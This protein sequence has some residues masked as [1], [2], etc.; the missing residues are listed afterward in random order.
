M[1]DVEQKIPDDDSP[2]QPI[3]KQPISEA[4]H[5]DELY[6]H[7]KILYYILYPL[8]WLLDINC[9]RKRTWIQIPLLTYFTEVTQLMMAITFVQVH[10]QGLE[11]RATFHKIKVE[12]VALSLFLFT[13]IIAVLCLTLLYC[14][15]RFTTPLHYI[16]FVQLSTHLV[17]YGLLYLCVLIQYEYFSDTV[18]NSWNWFFI[19]LAGACATIAIIILIKIF[20]FKQTSTN[21]LIKQYRKYYQ[22]YKTDDNPNM[23]INNNDSEMIALI[24]TESNDSYHNYELMDAEQSLSIINN[25]WYTVFMLLQNMWSISIGFILIEC[26]VYLFINDYINLLV[27]WQEFRNMNSILDNIWSIILFG[28]VLAIATAFME[29]FMELKCKIPCYQFINNSNN[30]N[31]GYRNNCYH[32]FLVF[33]LHW[34][35]DISILWFDILA[36]CIGWSLLTPNQANEVWDQ[37]EWAILGTIGF[38]V[39]GILTEK[40]RLKKKRNIFKKME[41]IKQDENDKEKKLMNNVRNLIFYEQM[42]KTYNAAFA[43]A[44]SFAWETFIQLALEHTATG[45]VGLEN[46]RLT[47]VLTLVYAIF[48]GF[49]FTEL[50]LLLNDL[51][52]QRLHEIR[53]KNERLNEQ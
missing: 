42:H 37:F 21:H 52:K 49:A 9:I 26:V 44:V 31:I 28:F 46:H 6:C 53:L 20:I 39:F 45:W 24:P 32:K 43:V 11:T 40:Y 41:K 10:I 4:V 18:N 16:Y 5:Y 34:L 33:L 7:Q 8:I 23:N 30:N 22:L 1:T 50:G 27:R 12:T 13:V 3:T 35:D 15:K 38:V 36:A 2:I 25:F 19:L 48:I 47:L 51:R 17:G 14:F 29:G